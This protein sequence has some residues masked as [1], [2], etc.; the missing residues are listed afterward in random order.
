VPEMRRALT[1]LELR[2]AVKANDK[3]FA[4][5]KPEAEAVAHIA[6]TYNTTED[7]ARAFIAWI[8]GGPATDPAAPPKGRVLETWHKQGDLEKGAEVLLSDADS[9]KARAKVKKKR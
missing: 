3:F 1:V 9:A 7:S 8:K 5:G 6:K 4:A 2:Q